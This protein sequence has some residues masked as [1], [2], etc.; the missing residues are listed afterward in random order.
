MVHTFTDTEIAVMKAE[1]AA[2]QAEYEA[3]RRAHC[4][5]LDEERAAWAAFTAKDKNGATALTPACGENNV[6]ITH[7]GSC[8][9]QA[10]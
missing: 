7:T 3:L 5:L 6:T 1:A 8:E 4:K 9:S 10:G 2:K